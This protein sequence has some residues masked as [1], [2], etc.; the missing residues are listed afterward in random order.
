MVNILRWSSQRWGVVVIMRITLHLVKI[1]LQN[2][3]VNKINQF[4]GVGELIL[5]DG[6]QSPFHS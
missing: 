1:L 2:S 4:H 5:H 6:V 3:V